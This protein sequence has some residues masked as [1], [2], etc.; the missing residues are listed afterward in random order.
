MVHIGVTLNNTSQLVA[1]PLQYR[2]VDPASPASSLLTA[3]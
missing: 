2:P 3:A 1:L